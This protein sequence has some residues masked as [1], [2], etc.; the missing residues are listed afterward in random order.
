MSSDN[1]HE[2][3]PAA[4]RAAAARERLFAAAWDDVIAV[5]IQD[6]LGRLSLEAVAARAGV[7]RATAYRLWSETGITPREAFR[8]DFGRWARA[9]I[10]RRLDEPDDTL[11]EMVMEL[12]ARPVPTSVEERRAEMNRAIRM[13]L[14]ANHRYGAADQRNL[15][16]IALRAS[17]LSQML[18]AGQDVAPW[19]VDEIPDAQAY[20]QLYEVLLER[21]R[22]RLIEPMTLP[23]FA[24]MIFAVG[25]GFTLVEGKDPGHVKAQLPGDTE[26]EAWSMWALTFEAIARAYLVFDD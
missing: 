12:L 26:P 4:R 20:L 17:E 19:T 8:R 1:D 9:E 23:M 15:A 21:Y 24:Q 2:F 6:G 14:D 7:S 22:G 18:A 16:T 13:V 10:K 3:T 5:G 25:I 11:M